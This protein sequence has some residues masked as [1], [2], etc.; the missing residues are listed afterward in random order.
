M[1]IQVKELS[2]KSKGE[3]AKMPSGMAVL[4][5]ASLKHASLILSLL[6]SSRAL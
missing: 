3:V 2:E 4:R 1:Y 5:L 6:C